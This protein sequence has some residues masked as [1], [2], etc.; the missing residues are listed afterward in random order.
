VPP[1]GTDTKIGPY[2]VGGTT[3]ADFVI[4]Y[5]KAAGV[6]VTKSRRAFALKRAVAASVA[7]SGNTLTAFQFP[8]GAVG[9]SLITYGPLAVGQPLGIVAPDRGGA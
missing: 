6:E 3:V 4:R 8:D 2:T 9:G 5:G 7:R 1:C